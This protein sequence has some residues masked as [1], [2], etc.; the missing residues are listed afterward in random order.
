M[1]GVVTKVG[2]LALS[3]I[4]ATTSIGLC[5]GSDPG[6]PWRFALSLQLGTAVGGPASGIADRL[7]QVGYD[8]ETTCWLFC[9][10]TISHPSEQ[11][12]TAAAG[13]MVRYMLNEHLLIGTGVSM[14]DMGGSHG[15][16][17]DTFDYIFSYWTASM[18]WASA[19][20]TESGFRLGGGPSWYRLKDDETSDRNRVTR[21]GLMG[22]AGLEVPA[23]KRF[24]LDFAIRVHLVPSKDVAYEVPDRSAVT[25]RPN[26]T[27]V[28]LMAGLGIHM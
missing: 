5:Q 27:H 26:W 6:P 18:M 28:Q 19:Y 14:L 12:P 20:W 21:F 17:S 11:Q 10:G 9:S 3:C 13:A 1:N 22:E 2:V 16:R 7:R 25:I 23:E 24:F 8:D 4:A 15:Y